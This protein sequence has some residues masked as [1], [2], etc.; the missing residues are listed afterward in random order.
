MSAMWHGLSE[1]LLSL[2]GRREAP[3]K[4]GKAPTSILFA[5]VLQRPEFGI[6][7]WARLTT[8]QSASS[9]HPEGVDRKKKEVEKIFFE[10]DAV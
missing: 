10:V 3:P 7:S 6:Y 4:Q 5:A 9:I 8:L 2:L 1:V